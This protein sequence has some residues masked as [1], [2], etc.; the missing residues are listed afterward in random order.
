MQ[1]EKLIIIC[2]IYL[3]IIITCLNF[4]VLNNC[5]RVRLLWNACERLLQSYCFDSFEAD[6]EIDWVD[7]LSNFVETESTVTV[8]SS[9]RSRLSRSENQ[10]TQVESPH[11]MP[12]SR[13]VLFSHCPIACASLAIKT[14]WLALARLLALLVSIVVNGRQ[15]RHRW[16]CE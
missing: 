14:A 10:E 15:A 16:R 13:L 11:K 9:G 3:S 6:L 7:K 12:W 5:H 4:A 2:R 8:D 1:V